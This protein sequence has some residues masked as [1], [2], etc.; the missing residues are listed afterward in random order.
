ML[1][2]YSK[3]NLLKVKKYIIEHSPAPPPPLTTRKN[4]L[5]I[6]VETYNFI[7]DFIRGYGY[8][9]NV[10]EI[11]KNTKRCYGYV[12]HVVKDLV[13][14]GYLTQQFKQPRS[15]RIAAPLINSLKK[16]VEEEKTLI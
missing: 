6:H 7:D 4:L 14:L 2:V 8:S 3:H 16:K 12:Y 13:S 5:P 15:I 9:P 11:S 10:K 1:G